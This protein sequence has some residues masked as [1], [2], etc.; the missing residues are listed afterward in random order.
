MIIRLFLGRTRLDHDGNGTAIAYLVTPSLTSSIPL[1]PSPK[2]QGRLLVRRRVPGFF[3]QYWW[4][5]GRAVLQ[6]SRD[7][8]GLAVDTVVI[9]ITGMTLGLL[10]D[11][12]RATIMHYAV[13][14]T[15]SVVAVG[16]MATVGGLG[17]F[18]RHRLVARREAAAGLNRLAFFLALDTVGAAVALVHAAVYLFMWLSFAV[19][20]AV[21]AQMYAVTVA[22]V[23][24]CT[25]TS[26]LLTQLL[27]PGTAQLAA[28]VSALL[29]ALVARQGDPSPLV[30]RLQAFSF[31]RWALEGMV[32]SESNKL[33][34]VWL[35][36]RCADLAALRYDVRR[37]WGCI[38]ALV[39]LG[40][41]FRLLALVCLIRKS[42]A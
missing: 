34:G 36:A 9:A 20:R 6:R 28:A 23:Y 18:S 26:Y 30:R 17:T 14:T 2:R 41:L 25:G 32:V 3:R 33:S 37:F 8:L 39:G 11:R 12:G 16:L 4:C 13:S 40:L 15:Y 5:L 29:A 38:L 19:P 7:P 31:A 21:V 42:R 10:S 35:L 1:P 27:E 24:A 22:A